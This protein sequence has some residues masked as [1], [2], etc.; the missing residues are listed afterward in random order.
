MLPQTPRCSSELKVAKPVEDV[1][2][3]DTQ[4]FFPSV[5][6]NWVRIYNAMESSRD[7]KS[8]MKNMCNIMNTS[9]LPRNELVAGEVIKVINTMYIISLMDNNPD[10]FLNFELSVRG[11]CNTTKQPRFNFQMLSESSVQDNCIARIC[12]QLCYMVY[13]KTANTVYDLRQNGKL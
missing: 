13:Y 2:S 9:N 11:K 8:D 3:E 4:T 12:N 1:K 5:L 7:C 6:K 10:F